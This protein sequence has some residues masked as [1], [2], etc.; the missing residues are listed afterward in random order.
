MSVIFEAG[1]LDGCNITDGVYRGW[2]D[3]RG[4]GG[5][6]GWVGSQRR[7]KANTQKQMAV[8]CRQ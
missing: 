6:R 7:A 3:G 8:L 5:R 2:A 1:F 4:V